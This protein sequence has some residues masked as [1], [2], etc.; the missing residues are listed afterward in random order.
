[1]NENDKNHDG[2]IDYSEFK[3]ALMSVRE[4][5]RQMN[6]AMDVEWCL[7]AYLQT[8]P[9]LKIKIITNLK[10][11]S[12]T[13]AFSDAKAK[14][15]FCMKITTTPLTLGTT[16]STRDWLLSIGPI[17]SYSPF[18][19]QKKNFDFCSSPFLYSFK[20]DSSILACFQTTPTRVIC[21]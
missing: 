8:M 20:K 18:F 7:C 12:P 14:Q 5:T 10:K 11:G 6:T 1:M 19:W 21:F 2:V 3:N 9:N 4:M 17:F 13:A 16:F 15:P